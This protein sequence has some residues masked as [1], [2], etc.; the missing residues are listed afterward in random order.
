M[1]AY[2]PL[3]ADDPRI[4]QP[5]AVCGCSLAPGAVVTLI[6]LGPG[7]DTT[8]QAQAQIGGWYSCVGVVGH[9]LCAGLDFG[10]SDELHE[11]GGADEHRVV[12]SE[13]GLTAQQ[14]ARW[15]VRVDQLLAARPEVNAH[16][17]RNMAGEFAFSPAT[18]SLCAELAAI[19]VR[20]RAE[21]LAP[22]PRPMEAVGQRNGTPASGET[23]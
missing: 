20:A 5:C 21:V 13:E 11:G 22:A 9:A 8:H 16:Q 15:C 1:R 18:C 12:A 6:P 4:G 7:A 3:A 2:A 10:R 19:E 14:A 23:T 17:L